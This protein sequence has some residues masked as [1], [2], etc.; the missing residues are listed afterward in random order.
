V[1]IWISFFVAIISLLIIARKNLWLGL[2]VGALVL[3]LFNLKLPILIKTIILTLTDPEVLLLATAVG[4]IPLIGGM[5]QTSGL[6]NDLVNN[7][8]VKRKVFLGFSPAFMGLLPLPG[9]ALLSAPMLRKA[10]DDIGG[11]AYAAINV[12]FRHIL[13]MIYP[14]GS[15]LACSKMAQLDL[16]K[17]LIY[18]FPIFLIFFLIGYIFLLHRIDGK[19]PSPHKINYL[20]LIRP[21]IIIIAAPIVHI[22]ISRSGLKDELSLLIGIGVALTLVILIGKITFKQAISIIKIMKPWKFFL[23]IIGIFLF[24]YIFE[25]SDISS[26]IAKAVFSF[27]FL[28]V[29]L[30]AFLG[31]VTGR[32][33]LPV[34]ILLPIFL[35]KYSTSLLTPPV[36]ALM[37]S[38]VFVGYMISPVHPCVSISV[39]YFKSNF[40]SFVRKLILPALLCLIL[41]YLASFFFLGVN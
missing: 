5:L 9:G 40:K 15:L 34:S 27:Q 25:N 8:Q 6:L 23:I 17:N 22:L 35:S 19:M 26:E 28:V 29:V 1:L 18:I 31:F 14:L 10:G 16:Y 24:L 13:I 37:Y 36:F 4:T 30:A 41:L 3:G 33:Q 2:T 39:E 11:D 20:K 38:S 12:W 21:I 32:I 7:L